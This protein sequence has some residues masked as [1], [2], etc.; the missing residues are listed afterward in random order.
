MRRLVDSRLSTK[1]LAVIWPIVLAIGCG[2]ASPWVDV[3]VERGVP[4]M[5][6]KGGVG[7][8]SYLLDTGSIAWVFDEKTFATSKTPIGGGLIKWGL[9]LAANQYPDGPFGRQDFTRINVLDLSLLSEKTKLKII[10]VAG[11]PAFR[12]RVVQIDYANHRLRELSRGLM[13]AEKLGER[14]QIID[15]DG[16]ISTKLKINGQHSC[17]VLIDTGATDFIRV[18]PSEKAHFGW[19]EGMPEEVDRLATANGV[20]QGSSFRPKDLDVNGI[21][22]HRPRIAVNVDPGRKLVGNSIGG[23]FLASYLVTIDVAG[24]AMYLKLTTPATPTTRPASTSPS[25]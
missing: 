11:E 21:K 23:E 24:G 8:G 7:V 13:T 5:P 6:S 12:T 10:G 14:W 4:F 17:T 25:H 20:L 3:T 19:Q 2:G 1:R 9:D 15:V 16:V 22:F 18:D